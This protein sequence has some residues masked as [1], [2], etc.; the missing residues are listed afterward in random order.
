M[1]WLRDHVTVGVRVRRADNPRHRGRVAAVFGT[2]PQVANR[3]IAWDAATYRVD[4]DCGWREDCQRDE[5]VR[6]ESSS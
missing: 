3:G 1:T 4:W 6:D 2:A 5:I